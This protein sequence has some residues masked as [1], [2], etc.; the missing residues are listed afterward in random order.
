MIETA[1]AAATRRVAEALPATMEAALRIG[2]DHRA[3][4]LWEI[5]LAAGRPPLP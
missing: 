2:R 5:A 4:I 1:D 3:T